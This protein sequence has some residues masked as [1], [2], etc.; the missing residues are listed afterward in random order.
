MSSITI[1]VCRMSLV[2]TTLCRLQQTLLLF[3]SS[4]SVSLSD[5]FV[6]VNPLESQGF[7]G[8]VLAGGWS[9]PAELHLTK[10]SAMP[11]GYHWRRVQSGTCVLTFITSLVPACNEKNLPASHCSGSPLAVKRSPVDFLPIFSCS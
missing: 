3:P 9:R 8:F 2:P 4:I 11:C 7:L 5:M 10:L 1:T 6:C